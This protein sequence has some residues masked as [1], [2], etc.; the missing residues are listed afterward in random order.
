MVAHGGGITINDNASGTPY[1]A[2]VSFSGLVDKISSVSVHIIG[3]SHTFP[4]DVAM[5]LVGPNGQ[6]CCLMNA[7]GDGTDAVNV[8]LGFTETAL[9]HLPGSFAGQIVSGTFLPLNTNPGM[10]FNAPAPSGPYGS[11][12]SVF[13]GANP[14]GTWSLYVLDDVNADSGSIAAWDLTLYMSAQCKADINDDGR[15]TVQDIFD[16]LSAWFAG[17]P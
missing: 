7:C 4:H 6:T 9:T 13:N 16:F 1:P 5:L 12:L 8:E 3:F 17:C 14:N 2:N 11:D 15:V 10:N